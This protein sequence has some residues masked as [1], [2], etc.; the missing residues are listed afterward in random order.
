MKKCFKNGKNKSEKIAGNWLDR[1]G[2]SGVA[3]QPPIP[4]IFCSFGM[5]FQ[6]RAIA[7][8]NRPTARSNH[9]ASGSSI[10]RMFIFGGEDAAERILADF[11]SFDVVTSQWQQL[12]PADAAEPRPSARAGASLVVDHGN[13]FVWLF[14]GDA[15][16]AAGRR[17]N[18]LWRWS[19]AER[20]W[21]QIHAG[22]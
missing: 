17:L 7:A 16:A 5:S 3:Q 11:W 14:G 18:D 10:G 13:A 8:A 1:G 9:A 22:F 21:Q 15:G 4:F 19:I 20:S 2:G 6:I 12:Q